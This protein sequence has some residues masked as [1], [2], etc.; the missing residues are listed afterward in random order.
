MIQTSIFAELE[1]VTPS[2]SLPV[3][4]AECKT[5][6]KE[7]YGTDTDEDALLT[8]LIET[9]TEKLQEYS[10]LSFISRSVIA[11]FDSYDKVLELPYGPVSSLTSVTRTYEGEDTVLTTSDYH[12]LGGAFK[13]LS[14]NQLYSTSGFCT[15]GLKVAYDCGYADADSV[16][17]TIKTAILIEVANHYFNRGDVGVTRLSKMAKETIRPLSRNI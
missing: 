9:A 15:Y 1:I 14:I 4:L 16:P 11:H 2:A 6:I 7:E 17:S 5:W 13:K 3:T 8:R 10:G 12:E